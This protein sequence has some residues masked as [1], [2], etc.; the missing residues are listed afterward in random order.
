MVIKNG[1]VAD[2]DEVL[3][4]LIGEPFKNW[5][6]VLF[7]TAYNEEGDTS[8][9]NAKLGYNRKTAVGGVGQFKNFV[10]STLQ[11]DDAASKSNVT[12]D[13]LNDNINTISW[14]NA[15][16]YYTFNDGNLSGNDLADMMGTG[17]NLTNSGATTGVNRLAGDIGEAWDFDGTNDSAAFDSNPV[18]LNDDFS[19]SVWVNVDNHTTERVIFGTGDG[20]GN[21]GLALTMDTGGKFTAW[22]HNVS[23]STTTTTFSD[24]TDYHILY[25]YEPAGNPKHKMWVNA[26]AQTL[27]NNNAVI[28]HSGVDVYR[29][30]TRDNSSLWFDGT[31]DEMVFYDGALLDGTDATTIYN[32]GNGYTFDEYN[33][34]SPSVYTSGALTT[35]TTYNNCIVIV[36]S[37]IDSGH[38]EKIEVTA[39]GGTNWEEV[40]ANE[41]HRFTNTG[42]DLRFRWTSTHTDSGVID[43]LSEYAIL[44]NLGAGTA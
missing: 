12:Y 21:V 6:Q 35:G 2:A 20:H 29:V 19:I 36:N 32:S 24:N 42:T 37:I 10:F 1:N 8:S 41:I 18:T 23:I 15:T 22:A 40:T 5:A 4:N 30:G 13:S 7:N 17:N 38:T 39:N 26:V 43:T 25:V 11:T 28:L 14:E 16:S 3:S 31:I 34:A 44:Y 33:E 9:W 27:S